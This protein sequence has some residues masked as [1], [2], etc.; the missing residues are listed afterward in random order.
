MGSALLQQWRAVANSDFR[1]HSFLVI[2]PAVNAGS[3]DDFGPISYVNAPP[4]VDQCNF[5]LVIVAVKPQIVDAVLPDYAERLAKD[6]FVASVAAGC[7]LSRLSKLAGDVPVVRIMPNLPAS[8]GQGVSGLCADATATEAQRKAVEALMKAAGMVLWVDD[9]DKLDRLT[10]VAGSGPGY[11]FEI[12]R[13]YVQAAQNIGFSA[14]EA[15]KLVLG[16]I[17]GTVAMAQ[18][19]PESL[20]DLRASVTSKNG[21]T[22]AGL[23]ALNGDGGLDTRLQATVDFGLSPGCRASVKVTGGCERKARPPIR[24]LL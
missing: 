1:D 23:D 20:D 14:D 12:A 21:T 11:V 9:E 5:D 4:P 17:A 16:T 10:A 8:I 2:D 6:G 22:A 24:N 19:S 7:S 3:A 13:A 18:G 15:R